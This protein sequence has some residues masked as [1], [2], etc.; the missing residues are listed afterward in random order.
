MRRL[1]ST[2]GP[3][4]AAWISKRLFAE[5][6]SLLTERGLLREST[7]VDANMSQ[8][9]RLLHGQ[10]ERVSADRGYDYPPVHAHLQARLMEDG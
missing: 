10:E 7:T 5:V 8:F 2:F 9:T 4:G 1:F 6:T 3:A